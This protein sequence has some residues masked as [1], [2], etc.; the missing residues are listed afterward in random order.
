MM[1]P[2]LSSKVAPFIAS[3]HLSIKDIAIE[4]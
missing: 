4:A 2:D 1:I 3:A